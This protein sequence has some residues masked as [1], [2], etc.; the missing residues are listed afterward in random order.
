M[1]IAH[2]GNELARD[3]HNPQ[4]CRP[5]GPP[6]GSSGSLLPAVRDHACPTAQGPPKALACWSGAFGPEA[7]ALW[8]W[9][10]SVAA[11][12]RRGHRSGNPREVLARS[13]GLRPAALAR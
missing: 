11:G 6:A 4:P 7:L 8:I 13:L 12:F 3:P 5:L 9:G 1:V 2:A 10:G